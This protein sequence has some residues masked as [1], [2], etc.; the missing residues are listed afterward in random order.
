MERLQST[1]FVLALSFIAF[2]LG[3]LLVLSEAPPADSLRNAYL[4]G[5]ALVESVG[6]DEDV[7]QTDLW[8]PTRRPERGVTRHDPG[9]AFP[10]YTLYTSGHAQAAL[11]VDMDGRVRHQ[12]HLPFARVWDESAR[13]RDPRPAPFLYLDRARVL[14]DGSLIAIY[15]GAGSTPW[16]YGMVKM[17]AD[18]RPIWK[19]LEQAHHDFD[20]A[21]NGDIYLL[22]HEIRRD[23]VPKRPQLRAP[24]IDDFLVVLDADGHPKRKIPLLKTLAKSRYARLL[25]TIPGFAFEGKGDF[26]HPNTVEVLRGP[27]SARFAY[28]KAGDVLLSFRD[29][30]LIAVLDPHTEEYSWMLRGSW[31]GQHDPTLLADGRLLLFDNFGHFGP[32]GRSRVIEID[33]G[34]GGVVWQYAGRGES[35]LDS[36]IRG[37]QQRLPNGNTLITESDG[38]R[39]L[40]V[41]RS[42]E[43]VWEYLNPARGGRDGEYTAVVSGGLRIAADHFTAPFRARLEPAPDPIANR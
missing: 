33:P 43:V 29:L 4:A 37:G 14:P 32:G 2:V 12:W 6:A 34:T 35:P 9:R 25:D 10:G 31:I 3:G 38:G 15:A 5:K 42:G 11:L 13:M 28:G 16:G 8:R 7:Y 22:T 23:R 24:R 30:G 20:I 41:T 26:L 18:S 40:E 19:Y 39:L 21:P 17:D 1:L 27:G 36:K